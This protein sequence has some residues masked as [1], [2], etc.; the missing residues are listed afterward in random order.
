MI[1]THTPLKLDTSDDL[2]S[3]KFKIHP[4]NFAKLFKL[5]ENSLYSDKPGSVMRE[6]VS[7]IKDAHVAN[8]TPDKVG[9]VKWVTGNQLIGNAYSISFQ[10]FGTGLS[11]EMFEEYFCGY[12]NSSKDQSNE[13]IGSYGLGCKAAFSISDSFTVDTI[14]E[15]VNTTYLCYKDSQSLPT[16]SILNQKE[17]FE[18]NG[19]TVT[20]PVKNPSFKT[21]F[22]HAI[23]IQLPYFKGINYVGFDSPEVKVMYEDEHCIIYDKSPYRY[24]H[25]IVGNIAYPLSS[26]KL[27]LQER[28]YYTYTNS[29]QY[30]YLKD[31]KVCLKFGIGEIHPTLS[32]EDIEY[33]DISIPKIKQ[34][35]K[36]VQ[37]NIKKKIAEFLDKETDYL[38]M[39]TQVHL[40]QTDQFSNHW[41][42]CK[43]KDTDFKFKNSLRV[44]DSL[45]KY[46]NGYVIQRVETPGWSRKKRKVSGVY[47]TASANINDLKNYPIY[48]KSGNYSSE[49]NKHLLDTIGSFLTISPVTLLPDNFVKDDYYKATEEYVQTL[50]TYEDVDVPEGVVIEKDGEAYRALLKERKLNKEYTYKQLGQGYTFN[51]K[52]SK[53][54]IFDDKTIVYIGTDNKADELSM[55]R[56]AK[57]LGCHANCSVGSGW[58]SS[59]KFTSVQFLK[60]SKDLYKELEKYD[61]AFSIDKIKD[62]SKINNFILDLYYDAELRKEYNELNSKYFLLNI[63]LVKDGPYRSLLTTVEN[64]LRLFKSRVLDNVHLQTLIGDKK[65]VDTF[66][67][68]INTLTTFLEKN[69]LLFSINLGPTTH[70]L[71]DAQKIELTQQLIKS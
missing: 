58:D 37:E 56:L 54:D 50:K 28:P 16:F 63:Y 59:F 9:I 62:S 26:S 4:K 67:E 31:C 51:N 48:Y 49:K 10:D 21:N 2:D 15:G 8:G 30:E 41:D 6:Y 66:P 39:F 52:V 27:G 13:S 7:N 29:P 20:I 47:T 38:K 19:T 5:L 33:D 1:L 65:Q 68:A 18:G 22:Q 12:L 45:E 57:I 60:V 43:I 53:L 46:V 70:N 36:I 71:D 25:C 64:Q 35:L 23:N 32:R 17:S 42:F 69:N 34:K 24:L 14:Y 61:N 44:I 55:V 11:Q 40:K 3:G